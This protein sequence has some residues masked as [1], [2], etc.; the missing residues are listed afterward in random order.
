VTA[1]RR[2]SLRRAA[3]RL[4]PLVLLAACAATLAQALQVRELR[5]AGTRRF[6]AAEVERT[7]RVAL[8]TPTVAVRPEE[9]R[10]AVRQIPWV[11]DAEVRVSLDGVVACTV[12]ERQPVAVAHDNGRRTLIDAE[13]A[14]LAPA[15]AAAPSLELAGFGAYPHERAA[16]LA[17]VAGFEAAW[18]GRVTRVTR[19]AS[20][21]VA[22]EFDGGVCPIAVDPAAPAG[23]VNARAVLRAWF[24][25]HGSA[26]LRL[27]ARVPGRVAVLPAPEPEPEPITGEGA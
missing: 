17:A 24:A 3:L 18:G 12:R 22:V 21:D 26:P 1:A 5:V 19:L 2:R 9:L 16:V 27:D 23:L 25:E 13:G 4:L 20:R 14:L 7:L 8:G 11:A 6:P 15:A 10:A